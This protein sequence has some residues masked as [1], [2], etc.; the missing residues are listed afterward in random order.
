M[1]LYDINGIFLYAVNDNSCGTAS[2]ISGYS[3]PFSGQYSIRVRAFDTTSG[4]GSF[5]AVY[6]LQGDAAIFSSGFE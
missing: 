2:S 5:N 4:T 1:E 6:R 3:P